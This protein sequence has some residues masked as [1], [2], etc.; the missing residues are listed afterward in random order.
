MWMDLVLIV[1]V[2]FP[3]LGLGQHRRLFS[4]GIRERMKRHLIPWG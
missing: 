2:L 1:F 4:E 3:F